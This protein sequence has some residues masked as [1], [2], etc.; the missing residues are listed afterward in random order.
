MDNAYA[1]MT[2]GS[3]DIVPKEAWIIYSRASDH[4]TGNLRLLSNP[5]NLHNQSRINLP[6]GE[7]S[8]ISHK[9]SVL[10][11]TTLTLNDV[12]HVP[13]F[14]HNLLSVQKLSRDEHCKVIFE[15]TSCTIIDQA[16]AQVKGKGQAINGLYYFIDNTSSLS[17]K[18]HI[19]TAANSMHI[20]DMI[21]GIPPLP[22]SVLWHHRLGHAPLDR[23]RKL[24]PFY[25]LAPTT[26]EV[27]IICPL[28]KFT[29]KPYSLSPSRASQPFSLVHIDIWGPYRVP[30]KTNYRYLSSSPAQGILLTNQSQAT[31]TAYCDSDWAGCSVTRRSTSGFC[32]LLG[33]SPI[34]WKAKRQSIVARSSGE[35][36]YRAM[37]LTI[38]EVMWLKKLFKDLGLKHTGIT[39]LYCDNKAA[40]AIASNL[41]HHERMKH[42][43]IDYHFIRDQVN[44]HTV[45]PTYIPSH[46][47][48][49]DVFTKILTTTQHAHLLHKLGVRPSSSQL[50]GEC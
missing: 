5:L 1:G 33:Q 10:I 13:T 31:L 28:A 48:V 23:I 3:H 20:P 8:V 49:A 26:G 45:H 27:C 11:N 2:Y 34:S 38:C 39:T 44:A 24:A 25:H 7:T 47:Q 37:A 9:G 42:V 6:N 18:P 29:K 16:T 36:E 32:I 14:K 22:P 40:L 46:S 4:M 17:S 30:T 21:Q 50:E 12:L 19:S 43:D 15:P 41:V 35:A